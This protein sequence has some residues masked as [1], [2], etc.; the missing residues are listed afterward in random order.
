M[1]RFLSAFFGIAL[2]AL[3]FANSGYIA[4]PGSSEPFS[5]TNEI[6]PTEP[7]ESPS[8]TDGCTDPS[9]CNY[10]PAATSEDGS[11]DYCSCAEPA[12][13]L[14]VAEYA[15]DIV[16]GYTTYRFYLNMVNEDDFLSVVYGND[17]EPMSL[18]FA[19]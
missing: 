9:A 4:S 2:P 12:Y 11:C 8:I 7:D 19:E 14:T 16:P 6:S 1:S 10:D 18:H 15:V 3:L 17:E 13:S 5:T